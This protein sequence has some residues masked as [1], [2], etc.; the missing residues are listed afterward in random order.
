MEHAIRF[1]ELRWLQEVAASA[2]SRTIP[3]MV[4]ASL[5]KRGLIE[6][7]SGSLRVTA[8]GRIALAKLS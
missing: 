7:H 5:L 1:E 4:R 3:D 2:S 6:P 8:K